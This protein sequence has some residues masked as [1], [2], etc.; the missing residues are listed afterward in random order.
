MSALFSTNPALLLRLVG[1]LA[2]AVGLIHDVDA[3]VQTDW[4]Q[5][6]SRLALMTVLIERGLI[7]LIGLALFSLGQGLARSEAPA[8]QRWG[9]Q[10]LAALLG[11]LYLVILPVQF[12]ENLALEKQTQ[13]EI[14]TK[15]SQLDAQ[16]AAP[17]AGPMADPA[18]LKPLRAE[19]EKQQ[20]QVG[21]QLARL[22]WKLGLNALLLGFGYLWLAAQSG[23]DRRAAAD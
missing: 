6:Q 1:A 16:L 7:P 23:R 14:R 17:N 20:Q 8:L 18:M 22:R 13:Q 9:L 4:S 21:G 2:V 19:L 3:L 12:T 10:G 15:L 11:A 5:S